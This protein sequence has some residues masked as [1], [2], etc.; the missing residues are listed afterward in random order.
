MYA[1]SCFLLT[2]A[3][4]LCM[5]QT[6]RPAESRVGPPFPRIANC[7][8][9]ELG[10]RTSRDELDKMARYDLLIG[11]T[12]C[13]WRKPQ[14]VASF[15][16]NLAYLR[17]INP[18][19][20]VL[21]FS[22]SAPYLARWETQEGFPADGWLLTPDGK[23]INGWPGSKMIN[24]SHSDVIAWQVRRSHDAIAVHGHHGTFIDCM[25]PQ[26]DWWACEIATGKSCQIDA[27]RDGRPDAK[28]AL[29]D[30]WK[31]AKLAMARQVR[32]AIGP[33][34]I[35]MGNQAGRET[36]DVINGILLE[37]YLDYVLDGKR[38]WRS[39]LD[40]YLY[41]TGTPY[42]PNITTIVSSSGIEPPFEAKQSLSKAEQ[43][44]LLESGQK[45]LQRMR[46]GLTTALMGDGYFAYD[47]HTRWRGQH[48]WY[49]EYDAPLGYPQAAAREYPDGT[50]RRPFDRGMVVVNPTPSQATVETDVLAR[51]VSTG[52][53]GQTFV[54]PP[55]D[56]R[57]LL[58]PAKPA[59]GMGSQPTSRSFASGRTAEHCQSCPVPVWRATVRPMQ[60]PATTLL[61]ML[62]QYKPHYDRHTFAKKTVTDDRGALDRYAATHC[63]CRSSARPGR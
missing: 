42:R 62:L 36:F 12:H 29:N 11:G 44:K 34:G 23:P 39:V 61:W 28:A 13:D 51:D 59:P 53:T 60:D 7:Y 57:L 17:K 49:P 31:N 10:P 14:Q 27:D 41:W 50:W 1:Q 19:I 48:W 4:G 16:K 52:Q 25:A 26:F 20:I 32:E 46:F 55:R 56:G 22:S 2:L 24:L 37:D 38:T 35:F 58:M 8:G 54:I 21:E 30:T 63:G 40:D 33:D 3:A 18:Y 47:L 43:D 6:T 15:K 5:G 45:L 9:A